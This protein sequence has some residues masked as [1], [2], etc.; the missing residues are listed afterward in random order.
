M[1][2]SEE[3]NA[4]ERFELIVGILKD[5]NAR[6]GLKLVQGLVVKCS[7][8]IQIV[9]VSEEIMALQKFRKETDMEV[10]EEFRRLDR[11]RKIKHDALISQLVIVNRY[12][13]KTKILNGKIPF[14]GIFSLD[15]VLLK[16]LDRNRI[17][18]WAGYLVN[19]LRKRSLL[20]N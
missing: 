12:L 6:T 7:E 4:F 16:N 1:V 5:N 8:Y 15:P 20:S 9:V 3:D 2:I 13:F 10:M 17:A 11:L 18:E 14:G 19:A